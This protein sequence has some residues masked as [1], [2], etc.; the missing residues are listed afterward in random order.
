[1][2][3]WVDSSDD[4]GPGRGRGGSFPGALVGPTCTVEAGVA[5]QPPLVEE[6]T[7]DAADAAIVRAL[8]ANVVAAAVQLDDE[9]SEKPLL[10]HENMSTEGA[11]VAE[12]HGH[13]QTVASDAVPAHQEPLDSTSTLT[14]LDSSG[15]FYASTIDTAQTTVSHNRADAGPSPGSFTMVTTPFGTNGGAAS[16]SEGQLL[17]G[18]T[19]ARLD[20]P[21]N[22]SVRTVDHA[23]H[24]V[25]ARPAGTPRVST[26]EEGGLADTT[27]GSPNHGDAGAS[28]ATRSSQ[29]AQ[30]M[31]SFMESIKAAAQSTPQR[32][33]TSE[34]GT[35]SPTS[36]GG[37][38]VR[39]GERLRGLAEG[40]LG[41]KLLA[42]LKSGG[43]AGPPSTLHRRSQTEPST[44][45]TRQLD[46]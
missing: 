18:T 38:P 12:A 5:E 36:S 2:G 11:L 16:S 1:M 14:P 27:I 19:S 9:L 46:S 15:T 17:L 33:C 35:L 31:T 20:A 8:V 30:K 37:T 3:D 34:D 43:S 7:T 25:A 26:D 28:T 42:T 45:E 21:T 22:D 6:T 23:A 44:F 29:F 13:A 24:L 4:E 41:T 40:P 39:L 10:V 32:G